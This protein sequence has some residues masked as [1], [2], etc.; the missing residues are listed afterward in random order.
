MLVSGD[1][2][3][4]HQVHVIMVRQFIDIIEEGPHKS[5]PKSVVTEADQRHEGGIVAFVYLHRSPQIGGLEHR[6]PVARDDLF[7][8]V[9]LPDAIRA[10]T[11]Q[12]EHGLLLHR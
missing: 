5:A 2:R 8:R 6:S 3:A 4:V 7:C 9:K 12:H 10:A 1:L 11:C